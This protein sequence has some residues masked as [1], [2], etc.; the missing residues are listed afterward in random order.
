MWLIVLDSEVNVIVGPATG[1][2]KAESH[3]DDRKNDILVEPR[4]SYI[5]ALLLPP[6]VP[7]A[8]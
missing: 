5:L 8:C 4:L 6:T 1:D 3:V 7:S 2:G